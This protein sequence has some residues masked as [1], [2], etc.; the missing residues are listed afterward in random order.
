MRDW[1]RLNWRELLVR[2]ALIF[3]CFSLWPKGLV[4]WGIGLLVLAWIVDNGL[5]RF[6]ELLKEPLIQGV[7]VFCGA[8]VIGLLW[9]DFPI[10]FSGKWRKYFILLTIIPFFSLLNKERLLWAAGALIS[11]YL[12]MVALGG[13]Q[14]LVQEEQGV[15]W[16]GMSYL[17]YSAVLGLGV[18]VAVYGGWIASSRAQRAVAILLWVF[19]LALLFLQFNERARG[20]LLATLVTLLLIF[21]WYYRIKGRLLLGSVATIA[22]VTTLFAATSDVFHERLEDVSSDLQL[23]QQGNY[24]TSV[25]YRLAM[26]DVGLH[27]IAERPLLGYGTGMAKQYFED[28]IVTYKQGIY[29]ELPK[30]METKH[31]HN[32]LIE[33]AMHLGLLGVAAFIFLLWSWFRTFKQHQMGLLGSTIICFVF[34]CGMTDTFLLYSR[35]PPFLLIM[36]VVAIS[37][38]RYQG[39]L[40]FV[41]RG[42]API[43]STHKNTDVLF[44]TP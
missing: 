22:V 15:P 29:K 33:I 32:E 44:D 16:L 7:L 38:Q 39:N 42:S 28:S 26:W 12:G 21:C 20:V 37:W 23:S 5:S 8:W 36:T 31:F 4:Y 9:G 3:F 40:T 25:G 1:I 6:A 13:Y 2:I 19:A 41:S 35:I 17:G 11:S 30:F 10:D 43:G 14:C 27:G 34:L 24:H 18:L